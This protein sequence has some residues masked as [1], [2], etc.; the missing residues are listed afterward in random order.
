MSYIIF[1]IS[2]LIHLWPSKQGIFGEDFYA[3]VMSLRSPKQPPGHT[4]QP[5]KKTF[6]LLSVAALLR[7]KT[8]I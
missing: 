2:S 3:R 1:Y 7:D 8:P 6:N 4:T 5:E